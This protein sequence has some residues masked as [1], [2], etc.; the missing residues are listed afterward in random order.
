MFRTIATLSVATLMAGC[1]FAPV[2]Q[3]PA[4]PVPSAFPATQDAGARPV[5]IGTPGWNSYFADPRLKQLIAAALDNNVDLAGSAAR[6]EQ[7]RARFGIQDAQRLPSLDGTAGCGCSRQRIPA[8]NGADAGT[9]V[10]D[11]YTAGVGVS[12]FEID[13]WGRVR[14]L[15]EQARAQ[16]LSTVQGE[17]AFRIS[18]IGQVSAAYYDMRAGEARIALAEQTLQGRMEGLRIAQRRLDA[19]ITTTVDYDQSVLLTTQ[20]KSELA[21]LK[22]STEQAR[23]LLTLLVGGSLPAAAEPPLPLEA[24][25]VTMV[26]EPGLPS[27][28]LTERPDILEA[29]LNL[30]AANANIGAARAAFFPNISLTGNLGFA[31]PALGDLFNGSSRTWSFGPA[32]DLPIFDWGRRSAQLD[33]SRAQADEMIAVYQSTVQTAFREV[34]DAL[35]ARRGFAEQIEAME[36]TVAAQTR[37]SRTATRRYEQG[38]SIYLEVLDVERN[39]FNSRQQLIGLKSA[40]VQNEISLY[41]ALGGGRVD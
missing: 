7:A 2:Y 13:L 34:A 9:V 14:N 25:G 20:A 27:S 15:S 18:L 17:R 5:S 16:F 28:V 24:S 35:V 3:Q 41:V 39:L 37:L 11:N 38:L 1:N 8:L 31:S 36:Q 26:L 29:E 12:G 23:T 10:A 22:R 6:I 32:I 21:D 19:G 33:L 4:L 30:R 40:A